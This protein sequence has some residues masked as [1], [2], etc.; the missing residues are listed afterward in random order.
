L[1]ANFAKERAMSLNGDYDDA[2][3]FAKIVR[4]QMPA[5]KV[6]EDDQTLAF[7]DVFPQAKGHTL[8]IH[9]SAKARNLLD[10]EAADL[11][12][13]MLTVQRVART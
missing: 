8:V 5:A 6:F 9:K 1:A 4:G 2:N 7:M 3:I 10:V 11:Q 12:A 13:V